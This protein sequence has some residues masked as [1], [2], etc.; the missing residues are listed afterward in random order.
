MEGVS[1]QK[2]Y[3]WCQHG[4]LISSAA[5]GLS[6]SIFLSDLGVKHILFERH[7]GTSILPKAHIINQRT[8]EIFRQHGFVDDI[9][10]QGTPP[11][12]MSQVIW[13]TTL[14]GDGPLDRKVIGRIETWG[15][16]PGS[17]RRATYE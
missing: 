8:L 13:Q 12:Q 1:E 17:E 6:L 3:A 15:C 9:I 10:S 14:G 7:P 5:C 11:N 2:S 16:R 4:R